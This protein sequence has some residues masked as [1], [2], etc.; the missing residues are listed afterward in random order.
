MPTTGYFVDANLLVLFVVGSESPDLIPKH[1]RL[2]GYL[3]EDYDLLFLLL[4]EVDQVFVTPNTLTE[5]SN[6][7]G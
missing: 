4:D 5:T 6:L 3:A 1:R 2:K 7:L